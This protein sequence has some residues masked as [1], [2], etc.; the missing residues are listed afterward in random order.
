MKRVLIP[1]SAVLLAAACTNKTP[2]EIDDGPLFST[3]NEEESINLAT[4]IAMDTLASDERFLAGVDEVFT[5][6]VVIDEFGKAHVRLGQGHRGLNVEGGNAVLHLSSKGEYDG[7]NDDM[8]RFLSV[9]TNPTV[10]LD[11][12]IAEAET[13]LPDLLVHEL[14]DIDSLT[15]EELATLSESLEFTVNGAPEAELIVRRVKNHDHV[16]YK[17]TFEVDVINADGFLERMLLAAFMDA[18]ENK[19]TY[20]RNDIHSARNR[21]T[22]DRNNST[23]GGSLA[24]SENDGPHSD[25]VVNEAHDNAGIT[26]DYYNSRH[27]RDSYNGS[28]AT[29]NSYVHHDRNY[30]NAYWNGSQMVYGDGDGSTSRELTVL[31]IVAHELTHAVTDYSSDLIYSGE[32]GA[33]NEAMS[34]IFAAGAEAYRDGGANS[35]TWKIGEEAWTPGTSGDALR[36]MDNPCRGQNCSQ[37]SYTEHANYAN[38][39]TGSYDNYG[40]H[41]NSGILNHVFYLLVQGGTTTV[42]GLSGDVNVPSIG[43]AKAEAIAY[44]ANTVY[45]TASSDY[46][47]ARNAFANSASD[48]YGQAEV[49]AVHLAFDAVNVPGSPNGG[50]G[51][52]GGGD[53]NDVLT[54]SNLSGSTGNFDF[55]TV[56]VPGDATKLE[57]EISGGSG[58]ADLY[59]R[60]GNQP[61]TSSYDCRPYKG[62]NS[63]LCEFSPPSGGTYHIGIR[64]YSPYSGVSLVA[65]HDGGNGNGGGGIDPYSGQATNVSVPRNQWVHYQQLPVPAGA[66]NFT[67]RIEGGSG[68][69]DLYV[70]HGSQPTTS[71]YDCRPY[72]SGNTETCSF[73]NPSAGDWY[74]SLRGYRAASG[75]NLYVTYE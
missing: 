34:D 62:G 28:G 33:L 27:G 20:Q 42:D 73:D 15:E 70:R 47:A 58:D 29:I 43:M 13:I 51:N 32:S 37:G 54:Q 61:T 44:R 72:K 23:S 41:L 4:D 69:A 55:Y 68:D 10:G 8:S 14:Y 46:Q 7:F 16:V 22:Y 1:V 60:F 64:A 31:D 2:D 49:D 17:V 74:F 50:G 11:Q 65:R 9:N 30:V 66:S 52:N 59:V 38:R 21:R 53:L 25:W 24:R 75:V 5:D 36:Y 3:D 48:L 39:Y 63:E 26:Y 56:D 18:D 40:V 6:K 19:P 71:S 57:I 35:N 12:A 67:V 45:L